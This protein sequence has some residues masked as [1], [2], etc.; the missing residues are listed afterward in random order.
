MC[1][2]FLQLVQCQAKAHKV[3][4]L[5]NDFKEEFAKQVLEDLQKLLKPKPKLK[6]KRVLCDSDATTYEDMNCNRRIIATALAAEGAAGRRLQLVVSGMLHPA[7]L[8]HSWQALGRRN[9]SRLMTQQMSMDS[10]PSNTKQNKQQGAWK[11]VPRHKCL[12]AIA[13]SHDTDRV[14]IFTPANA[15]APPRHSNRSTVTPAL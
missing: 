13:K 7:A 9:R 6:V 10:R 14:W 3:I 5:L 15:K 2:A 8:G 11:I 12:D 4:R 1:T